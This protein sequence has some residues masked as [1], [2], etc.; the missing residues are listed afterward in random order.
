M[1]T[2]SRL[3]LIAGAIT[4]LAGIGTGVAYASIPAPDGTIHGCYKNSTGMLITIDSSASCPTGYTALNW[5]QTGPPG[6]STAGATGLD[7]VFVQATG[8][9][10]A[11]A[12]CP[13]DHPY[14]VSGGFSMA[15]ASANASFPVSGNGNGT[16]PEGTSGNGW[17]A[18]NATGSFIDVFAIC[19]K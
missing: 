18:S 14:V 11:I 15:S 13:S 2:R 7:L 17:E 19:A 12:S 5:S 10:Q 1:R 8:T 16:G 4:V 3:I 6:P 9:S